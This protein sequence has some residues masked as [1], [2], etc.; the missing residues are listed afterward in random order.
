MELAIDTSTRTAG[1]ALS[2]K[3]EILTELTWRAEH[4][5]TVQLIPSI[6]HLLGREHLKPPDLDAIVVAIGPGSFSGLRVGIS[7]AKGMAVSLGIPL[8]GIG[9]LALEAYPFSGS[10]S[11]ICPVLDAGRGELS[12]AV[13]EV[14]DGELTEVRSAGICSVEGL[15]ASISEP[16]LF[17]GEHMSTVQKELTDRLG[18]LAVFPPKSATL[19]RPGN[20]AALGWKRLEKGL[21]DDPATLQPLYLRGPSITPPR[22]TIAPVKR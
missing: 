6:N 22:P 11:A 9:T 1:V 8:A 4:N 5:H 17:C 20:L 10:A 19:R 2:D 3:G 16:T 18:P 15:C 14:R 13:F 7:A 21:A 12:T